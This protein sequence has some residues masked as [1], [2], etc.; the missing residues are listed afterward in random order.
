MSW[1]IGDYGEEMV[2]LALDTAHFASEPNDIRTRT[3][4]AK[5]CLRCGALVSSESIY[6]HDEHHRAN[7][8]HVE[9]QP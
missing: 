3:F 4:K 9:D 2:L 5:S 1:A 8:I 7:D 6:D